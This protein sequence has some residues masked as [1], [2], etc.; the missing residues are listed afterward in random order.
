M[1]NGKVAL[2]TGASRGIGKEIALTFASYGAKVVVN[3]NGSKEKAD[4]V[5]KEIEA[6]GGEAIAIQCSVAD[7]EACGNMVNEAIA[8]FGKVDILVNNAG[9][10]KDNLVMKISDEDFDAVIDTNLKGTFN[11]IKQLYR[12]FLKQ[13][14][15]RIINMTSVTGILGNAGQANYAASKA[16]VIGLTKSVARELATRGI[17]VN[18]IAPGFIATEMTDAMTDAAKQAVLSQIP[19]GRVGNTKDIAE[20]AAFLA[21]DKAAY[22][23][24]QVI[25][26]DGGMYM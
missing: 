9:I 5:V 7:Y 19:L 1:L 13:R 20:T 21:S 16:G 11:C 3:Y 15:G 4:E 14:S 10:T 23:T 26:V 25:S 18:A 2:I 24:G 22:I 12:P 17:T 6:M 8:K